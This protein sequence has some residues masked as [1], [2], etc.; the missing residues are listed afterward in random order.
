M[1]KL[2]YLLCWFMLTALA[3]ARPYKVAVVGLVHGHSWNHLKEL[4][5][6]DAAQ[7]VGLCETNPDLVTQAEKLGVASNLV[8]S[9]IPRMLDEV[10]PDIVWAF[11]ENNRHLEVARACASRGIS[12][13]YEKPLAST[14]ADAAAI[15]DLARKSGIFVLTNYQMAWWPSNTTAKQLVDAGTIGQVYR[16]HGIVGHGGP[17]SEGPANH[18]FFEWLTDPVKNGAGALVD[19]GCYSAAWSI[20]YLGPP[21]SVYARTGNQQPERFPKVED[22]AFLVLGYPQAT[23][24]IEAS[25]DLPRTYQDLDVMSRKGTIHMQQSGVEVTV[26]HAHPKPAPLVKLPPELASPLAC[27]I[28]AL[29]T[30]QAPDQG[31]V[32]L[33]L[34]VGVMEIIDAAKE[35]VRTGQVVTL[36]AR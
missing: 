34:N 12:I 29:E 6:S 10:K 24:L 32:G 17:G 7:L 22:Q 8:Y 4:L 25:W 31:I 2:K 20:W 11:V 18:A 21:T 35:S 30:K 36:P 15:R 27:M 26:G 1:T 33:D 23:A 14:Y 3:A 13:I 9:D 19:F 28:H 16:L 5:A